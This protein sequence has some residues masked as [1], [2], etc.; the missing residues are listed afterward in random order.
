MSIGQG[1]MR[2]YEGE[3]GERDGG[4]FKTSTKRDAKSLAVNSM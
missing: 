2:E 4:A 3:D 1:G